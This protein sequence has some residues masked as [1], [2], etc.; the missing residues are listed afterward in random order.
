VQ[1]TCSQGSQLSTEGRSAHWY[2]RAPI[3]SLQ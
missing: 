3:H 2:V 1:Y